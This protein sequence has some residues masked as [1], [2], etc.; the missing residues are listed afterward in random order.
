MISH[1]NLAIGAAAVG[2]PGKEGDTF[3]RVVGRSVALVL[4]T[5]V[6]V[7]LSSVLLTWMV[8]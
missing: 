7:L 2:P 4:L 6:L 1:Q 5:A 8:P 3:R